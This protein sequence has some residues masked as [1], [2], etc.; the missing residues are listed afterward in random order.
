VT[1]QT[2]PDHEL[3]R[4]IGGGGYGEVWLARNALGAYRAV[5]IVRRE[6]FEHD[7]PFERE[8]AGIQKFEPISR[9]H[10]GLVDL[11]QVGRNEAEGWFYY[12]MELADDANVA[13]GVP[14]AVEPGILPGGPGVASKK[15]PGTSQP[16]PGGK[17]PPS[18]AGADACRYAPHTLRS[19]IRRAGRLPLGE[20]LAIGLALT[21]ALGYLH[22]QGLVHR[23]IKPS[24]IIF[25]GGVPKLADVGLVASVG[26]ARSYVGTE[27]FI[28]PEGPGSPQADLYGLGIVLYVMSTGQRHEDFPAPLPDLAAQ[29]DHARWLEFNA[30]IHKACAA[31]PRQRYQSAEKMHGELAL[32][33]HGQSVRRKRTT[34]RRFTFA[35]KLSLAAVIIVILGLGSWLLSARLNRIPVAEK[36]TANLQAYNEYKLGG[37]FWNKRTGEGLNRAI[38]H[39]HRATELDPKFARAYAGL[40]DC[41]NLLAEYGTAT[42]AESKPKAREAAQRALALDDRLAE[43]HASLGKVLHEYDYDWAAAEREF[44]RAIEL[45]PTYPTARQWYGLY[46]DCVGRTDEAITQIRKGLELDPL[47]LI[48]NANLGYRHFFARRYDAAIEQL[49]KTSEMDPTF[50]LHNDLGWIYELKQMHDESVAAWEQGLVLSG[51]SPETVAALREEYQRGGMKAYLGKELERRRRPGKQAYASPCFLAYLHA[52]LGQ[53]DEAMACLESAYRERDPV[54]TRVHANPAIDPLRADPRFHALFRKMGLVK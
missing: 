49:R 16:N 54:L 26:E 41:Y 29:P 50:P 12:V 8:F 21:R 14:P 32:F 30:I 40:S 51:E 24:N 5:K 46:L 20:C 27:G 15:A 34:E 23:D 22:G 11:L 9:Q 7:R 18:T 52:H 53:N 37:F 3:L 1:T 17:L 13:A 33:Q 31:D 43:A 38:E 45:N 48:I 10:E 36:G 47:S 2:I 19:E 28:P 35:K 25:V 44:Q 39:F 4:R 6:S 42:P